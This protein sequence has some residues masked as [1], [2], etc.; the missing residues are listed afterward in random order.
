M[1][2]RRRDGRGGEAGGRKGTDFSLDSSTI[3]SNL[4]IDP[5][6]LAKDGSIDEIDQISTRLISR[7]SRL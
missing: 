6:V 7:Y 2:E 3:G 4:D 1:D 5:C